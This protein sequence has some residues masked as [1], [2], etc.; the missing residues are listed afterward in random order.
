MFE[1]DQE[2]VKTLLSTSD[3]FKRLHEKHQTLKEQ[4]QAANSGALA[5]DDV[6]LENLKKEKLLLKDKM[7]LMVRDYRQAH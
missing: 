5:L 3:A 7:S 2:I 4:V 6:A 1:F